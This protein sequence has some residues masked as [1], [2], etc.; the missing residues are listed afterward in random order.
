MAWEAHK[1]FARLPVVN[2]LEEYRQYY[3]EIAEI[4]LVA[5]LLWALGWP[6]FI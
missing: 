6:A 5:S 4:V 2:A 3:I 1:L